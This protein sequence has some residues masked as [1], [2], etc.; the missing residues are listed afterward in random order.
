M[1]IKEARN[2]PFFS[3]HAPIQVQAR[4]EAMGLV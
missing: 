2:N 1:L 4:D 3:R